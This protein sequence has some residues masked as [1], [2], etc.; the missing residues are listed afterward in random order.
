MKVFRTAW[1]A[2]FITLFFFVSAYGA[3]TKI[4][5]IDFQKVLRESKGGKAAK[6][7]I[8]TKGKGMENTLKKEGEQLEKLKK[9]LEAEAMVMS[10]EVREEKEREFRIKV[11]DFKALQKK[12]AGELREFEGEIIKR[13]QKDVFDIVEALGKSGSYDLILEKSTILY[14]PDALDITDEL[15]K[16]YDAR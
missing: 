1:V 11:G 7:E 16:K 12:Y 8:E 15:I 6:S 14:H 5:V 9:K 13:V 3:D 10:K 4:G 2:V